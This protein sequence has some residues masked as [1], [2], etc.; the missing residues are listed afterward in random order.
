MALW[1]VFDPKLRELGLISSPDVGKAM[2]NAAAR[3]ALTQLRRNPK[4]DTS[5]RIISATAS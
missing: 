1:N 4:G 5:K 2:Y 3:A